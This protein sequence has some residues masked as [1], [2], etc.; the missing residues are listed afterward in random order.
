RPSVSSCGTGATWTAR[1]RRRKPAAAPYMASARRC[2]L[3]RSSSP[4]MAGHRSAGGRACGSRLKSMALSMFNSPGRHF[5]GGQSFSELR[6]RPR[7]SGLRPGHRPPGQRSNLGVLHAFG[8]V[9]PHHLAIEFVE[10]CKGPRQVQGHIMITGL[11][12]LGDLGLLDG[13][14]AVLVHDLIDEDAAQ[15]EAELPGLPELADA[16]ESQHES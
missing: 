2:F 7:Q 12:A 13:L 5:A 15:P 16:L 9:Q 4:A 8:V 6:A 11:A 1:A 3:R 10:P 14:P